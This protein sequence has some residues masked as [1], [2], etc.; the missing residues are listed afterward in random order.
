MSFGVVRDLRSPR[1]LAT[2]EDA[3]AY[4]EHLL[5]EFVFARAAHGVLD[6]TIRQDVS[7]VEEFLEWVGVRAW[8]VEPRHAAEAGRGQR[9]GLGC[10]LRPGPQGR[11]GAG[12]GAQRLSVGGGEH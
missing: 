4:E 9:R 7:A 2:A 6:A 10:R 5:A 8:E 12:G 1:S 3:R 11:R